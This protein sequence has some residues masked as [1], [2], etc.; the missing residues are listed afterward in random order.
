MSRRS[1]SPPKIKEGKQEMIDTPTNKQSEQEFI[2]SFPTSYELLEELEEKNPAPKYI[3]PKRNLHRQPSTPREENALINLLTRPEHRDIKR[4]ILKNT[5]ATDRLN[6]MKISKTVFE[7]LGGRKNM[8]QE[9]NKYIKSTTMQIPPSNMSAKK[10]EE[11]KQQKMNRSDYLDEY[12][13]ITMNEFLDFIKDVEERLK[14]YDKSWIMYNYQSIED[15]E[16]DELNKQLYQ[17]LTKLK[18]TRKFIPFLI[19]SDNP[20]LIKRVL[21]ALKHA[22][23]IQKNRSLPEKIMDFNEGKIKTLMKFIQKIIIWLENLL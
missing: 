18:L 12:Q 8:I 5:K 9:Q 13:Q 17:I 19:E 11:L 21:K 6:L 1:S 2:S 10:F 14:K 15:E 20:L 22:V 7:E 16:Y 23:D 4:E 3:K